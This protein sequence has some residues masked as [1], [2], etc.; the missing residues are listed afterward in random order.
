MLEVSVEILRLSSSDRL[1]MTAL[2]N[3]ATKRRRSGEWPLR[4]LLR[5][6]AIAGARSNRDNKRTPK[7]SFGQDTAA[8]GLPHSK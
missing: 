5:D 2:E 4:F 8:A 6:S 1:R 7:Q 3:P